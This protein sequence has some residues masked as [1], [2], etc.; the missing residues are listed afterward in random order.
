MSEPKEMI[1]Q[2]TLLGQSKGEHRKS[3]VVFCSKG[4]VDLV[5]CLV[6]GAY[7]FYHLVAQLAKGR[8]R[9]VVL[10][11]GGILCSRTILSHSLCHWDPFRRDPC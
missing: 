11:F 6:A 3:V 5:L 2:P 8:F 9:I 1:R 10:S 4:L 7:F